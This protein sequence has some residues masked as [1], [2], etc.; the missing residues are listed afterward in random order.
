M[1]LGSSFGAA[2]Q[3][4]PPLYSSLRVGDKVFAAFSTNC[5]ECK[6]VKPVTCLKGC[7]TSFSPCR[8]GFTARCVHSLLLGSPSLDGAQAQYIR[9]PHA[10]A[11]LSLV[12][13][14]AGFS[15]SSTLLLADI[16]PTGLFAA[17]QALHHP[18]VRVFVE[19]KAWPPGSS[20][21]LRE[22]DTVLTFAIIGLGPVGICATVALLDMLASIEREWQVVCIDLNSIRRE[23]VLGIWEKMGISHKGRFQAHDPETAKATVKEWTENVGCTA[24]LEVRVDPNHVCV[25]ELITGCWPPECSC[26]RL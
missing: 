5:G 26:T 18:K 11:T 14:N 21:S 13:P 12:P 6:S 2:S 1:A 10:G 23:K 20:V 4:R 22:A 9:V 25:S 24:V 8:A 19:G 15:D 16:L 7:L 17:T 3:E